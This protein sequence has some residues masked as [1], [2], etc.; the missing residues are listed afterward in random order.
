V[1]SITSRNYYKNGTAG[2]GE[3][4]TAGTGLPNLKKR[5]DLLYANKYR[6]D[7]SKQDGTYSIDLKLELA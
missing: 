1:L 3:H 2:N 7:I 4:T 5:L 6:L